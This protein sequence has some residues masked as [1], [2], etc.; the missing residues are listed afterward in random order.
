MGQVVHIAQARKRKPRAVF[1]G[2]K[3]GQAVVVAMPARLRTK[4]PTPNGRVELRDVN[5]G[6]YCT[7]EC[8][9]VVRKMTVSPRSFD[10]INVWIQGTC[11]LFATRMLPQKHPDGMCF[12]TSPIRQLAGGVLSTNLAGYTSV[13]Y[14]P[15]TNELAAEFE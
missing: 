11:N 4:E 7:L 14:D 6:D 1:S 15:L 10:M 5:D 9:C 2:A 8:G 12:A 13:N 3:I